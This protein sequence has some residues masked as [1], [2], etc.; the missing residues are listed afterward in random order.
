MYIPNRD[1]FLFYRIK[2]VEP[3][4]LED[5][6]FRNAHVLMYR[7]SCLGERKRNTYKAAQMRRHKLYGINSTYIKD[8][9]RVT[10][11]SMILVDIKLRDYY[12]SEKGR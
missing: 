5:A 6:L 3:E 1:N 7:G 8:A 2:D 9:P 12:F 10:D 4:S 11:K